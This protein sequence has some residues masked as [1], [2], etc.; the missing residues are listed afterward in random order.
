MVQE[1]IFV[2][3][4]S[5]LLALQQVIPSA[6]KREFNTL[7]DG[8]SHIKAKEKYELTLLKIS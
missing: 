2:R 7:C 4:V 1:N 3:M 6:I 8:R 5:A